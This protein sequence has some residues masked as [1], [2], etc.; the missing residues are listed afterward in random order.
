MIYWQWEVWI[1]VDNEA[2]PY[3]AFGKRSDGVHINVTYS[4][5]Q[6]TAENLLIAIGAAM[7]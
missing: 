6:D 1:D 3:N 7:A 5:A 4:F 2:T